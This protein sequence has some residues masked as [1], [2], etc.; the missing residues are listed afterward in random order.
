MTSVSKLQ[1]HVEME[2]LEDNKYLSSEILKYLFQMNEDKG[3]AKNENSEYFGKYSVLGFKI[4]KR[5][6]FIRMKKSYEFALAL[7]NP[8][9]M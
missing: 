2:N 4:N 1:F 3:L 5:D 8:A 9:K 7:K 6:K